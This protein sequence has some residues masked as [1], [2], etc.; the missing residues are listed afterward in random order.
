MTATTRAAIVGTG[1]R[2]QL[3]T[4]GLARRD[5][6][7]VAALCDPNPVRMAHHNRLLAAAGRPRHAR[8]APT[9]FDE[10]AARRSAS[11]PSSSPPSTRCT[12]STSSPALRAGCRV[13]TEKPMTTDAERCRRILDTV[14]ETGGDAVGRLQLPLQPGARTGPPASCAAGAIGEVLSVH[15]EWLL[16]VRHGADYFRR[17]HREKDNSG[18]LMVHKAGHH[19]DLVNW[20]LGARP[21][22]V[23][24]ARPARLLRPRERRAHRLPAATTTARTARP[25]R[26]TTPS[27][28]TWR[29]TRGCAPSTSTPR[30]EDGYHRDRNVFGDGITIED[31]MAV[32]VRYDT[33]ASHVVPPHRLLALGGLPGDVQRHRRPAGAGGRGERSG[34]GRRPEADLRQGRGARRH[35]AGQRRRRAHPAC[36]RC[37]SRRARWRSRS[38]T[39]PGTAAA[40]RGCCVRCSTARRADGGRDGHAWTARSRS[41][42]VSAA[43]TLV[44]TRASRWTSTT[45]SAF[46]ERH[47]GRRRARGGGVRSPPSRA[48]SACRRRCAPTPASGCSRSRG[49]WTS[50]PT[51]W[52]VRSPGA[53]PARSACWF[54]T[55]STRTSRRSSSRCS[56]ARGPKDHALFLADTGDLPG[57]RVRPRPGHGPADRRP[58]AGRPADAGR[59]AARA[60]GRPAR[61]C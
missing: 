29:T 9:S 37:G 51:G 45:W 19:F 27:P 32:L 17:W 26:P 39:T 47:H 7:E 15:F 50:P 31:D 57:R 18:G 55:W 2:A 23:F 33:G 41:P 52:P 44:R 49:G 6:F 36:G 5:H 58:A 60:G 24:G 42:S 54:P 10:D 38:S 28:C 4:E 25:P 22:R 59:D 11:T 3:F 61:W 13:V 21:E 48:C 8:T 16:D 34:S 12:T 35:R 46:R 56:I 20:W 40:T 53:A 1:H 14:A 30:S 43:N